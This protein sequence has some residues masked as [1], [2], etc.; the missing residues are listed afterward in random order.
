MVS[1]IF[2]FH[3]ITWGNDPSLLVFFKWVGSTT[4]RNPMRL[5]FILPILYVFLQDDGPIN[6][7]LW[8]H[9]PKSLPIWPGIS[10]PRCTL[11]GEPRVICCEVHLH[12]SAVEGCT[13][14]HWFPAGNS[15]SISHLT[16]RTIIDFLKSAFCDGKGWLLLQKECFFY[17]QCTLEQW[18]NALVV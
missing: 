7:N 10:W 13:K 2:Y 9:A 17:L 11:A 4:T 3:P 15:S 6:R 8:R 12:L 1:N 14:S 18:K 16:N 5:F